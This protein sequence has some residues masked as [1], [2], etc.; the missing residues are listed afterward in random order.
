MLLL[1][2]GPES[3]LARQRVRELKEDA[4]VKG[5][6]VEDIDCGDTDSK[7]VFYKLNTPSLFDSQKLL[8]FH[9]AFLVKEFEEKDIQDILLKANLHTLVFVA[10]DAKKTSSLFKFLLRH[11]KSEE[12]LKLKGIDLKNWALR[13]IKK[14]D[15]SLAPEALEEL[16]FSCGDDLE[17]LAQEISKLAAF[18]YSFVKKEVTKH[19]VSVLVEKPLE[20]KIFST[21]DAICTRN[22]KLAIKLLSEHLHKGESPLQLLSM[23]AWQFRILLSQ[24]DLM[25]RG[26]PAGEIAQKLK[27]HPFV[28]KKNFIAAEL[29]SLNELK[30]LYKRIF[31]LDLAFKTGKGNP[32]QLLYLFAISAASKKTSDSSR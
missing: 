14:Y 6:L 3:Y 19:D 9:D 23:F 7:E 18:T 4:I 12:F 2:H 26:V 17:R 30:E 28:A 5:V 29:F 25:E 16:L 31:S 27:L 8:I 15:N 24:K 1:L 13:E 11:G 22:R 32:E 20:P 21:I 10:K